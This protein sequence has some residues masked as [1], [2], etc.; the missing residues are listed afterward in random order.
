M[1]NPLVSVIIPTYNRAGVIA[2]TLDSV[3]LQEYAD[4]ECLVVDD[5]STDESFAIIETFCASDT[6]FRLLKRPD[7]MQ[8]GAGS[9]RNLGFSESKGKF[10]CW[11]DSDDVISS[12]KIRAQVQRLLS[13]NADIAT[14]RWGRFST[15]SDPQMKQ[16]DIY[17]DY[18]RGLD[19]IQ[20]YG[21]TGSFFPSHVFLVRRSVVE[22]AGLWNEYLKINQ[23]GEFFSR[24][25]MFSDKVVFCSD[26]VA[27]YRSSTDNNT[28]NTLSAAK[29]DHLVRSWVLIKNNLELVDEARFEKY[30]NSGL[31]YVYTLLYKDY[32]D[33]IA[34][35]KWLFKKQIER[36]SLLS[37]LKRR[38]S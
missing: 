19:L 6:R 25:L 22:K 1:N 20:G 24:L 31:F 11:L 34:R 9:C 7:D 15:I 12:A 37:R 3:R 29:A 5:G 10:V 21:E 38:L 26:A 13:E 17:R 18:D 32:P 33:V 28:N 2:E 8:K 14:C 36:S 30:V 35:Y 16:L 4:W 27:L 23:D